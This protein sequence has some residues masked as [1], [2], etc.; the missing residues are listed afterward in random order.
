MEAVNAVHIPISKT[1]PRDVVFQSSVLV[2]LREIYRD[3]GLS[4]DPESYVFTNTFNGCRLW[5]QGFNSKW[6]LMS[7]ELGYPSE[8]SLY[9]S[10][11]TCITDR[12]INGTP[13]S[14]I[15]QNA[16]NSSRDIEESYRDVILQN[17]IAVMI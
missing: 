13:L 10:R 2:Q 7:E 5:P 6:K 9:S 3:K 8:Y 12:I 16:G 15:A 17:N 11:S 14:L 1:G 4:I